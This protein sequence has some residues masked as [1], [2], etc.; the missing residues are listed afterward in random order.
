LP[1]PE[2]LQRDRLA[3]VQKKNNKKQ[4]GV[5]RQRLLFRIVVGRWGA[6]GDLAAWKDR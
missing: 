5:I 3:L 4:L 2:K 1:D 6:A